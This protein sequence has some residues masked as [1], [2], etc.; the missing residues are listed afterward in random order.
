MMRGENARTLAQRTAL[1]AFLIRVMSAGIAYFLQVLLAR[2]LGQYDYGIFVFVWV[3]VVIV[4]GILPLGMATTTQRFVPLHASRGEMEHLRG[5]LYGSR[6]FPMASGTVLAVVGAGIIYFFGDIA[7]SDYTLPLMIA[8][9][10][11]PMYALLEV[12]DG[13]A[14]NYS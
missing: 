2:G 9:V 12:Q 10:C 4:G 3:T 11:M 6:V 14:R 7:G 1:F 13:L 5:F 8:F